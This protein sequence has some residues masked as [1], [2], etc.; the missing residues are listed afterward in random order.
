MILNVAASGEDIVGGDV[1]V[2]GIDELKPILKVSFPLS[3]RV[4]LYRQSLNI[5]SVP[6]PVFT[7]SQCSAVIKDY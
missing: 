7:G 3:Q 4:Q 1:Q 2:D 5:V 6:I